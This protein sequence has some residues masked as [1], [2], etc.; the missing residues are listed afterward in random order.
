MDKNGTKICCGILGALVAVVFIWV[1]VYAVEKSK[2]NELKSAM[3]AGSSAN[4]CGPCGGNSLSPAPATSSTV[5]CGPCGRGTKNGNGKVARINKYS[6]Q[7][8]NGGMI[9]DDYQNDQE[10]DDGLEQI[11]DD[12]VDQYENN[13]DYAPTQPNRTK[14]AAV[15]GAAVGAAVGAT[16]ATAAAIAR[17][18]RAAASSPQP[19]P[20]N[21]RGVEAAQVGG[22]GGGVRYHGSTPENRIHFIESPFDDTPAMAG[23]GD[24]NQMMM[25]HML[26]VDDLPH[27]PDPRQAMAPMK[28]KPAAPSRKTNGKGGAAPSGPAQEIE[29][30]QLDEIAEY[31]DKAVIMLYAPWC[32]H[33]HDTR[34]SF[35]RAA[36][37]TNVPF[38]AC[39][40]DGADPNVLQQKY[41]VQGFPHIMVL[42][43]GQQPKEYRGDRS[44]GSF[45]RFAEE[46]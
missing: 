24:N 36:S 43:K 1:I 37:E 14:A 25:D 11:Y 38:Y 39:N 21:A 34:P 3:S 20:A 8:A 7:G 28:R 32:S 15:A 29:P 22:N 2:K 5:A 31:N 35:D 40:G 46:A 12:M 19:F 9:M 4:G 26:D 10:Y 27:L 33:C 13:Q 16:A 41:K 18:K 30:G 42:K 17:Q 6:T 44:P 45:V 23:Y